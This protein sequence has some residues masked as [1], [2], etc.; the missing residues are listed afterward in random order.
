MEQLGAKK[1]Y[2]RAEADDAT[3]MEPEVESWMEGLQPEIDTCLKQIR[4]LPN[5]ILA[6]MMKETPLEVAQASKEEDEGPAKSTQITFYCKLV[7]LVH[8]NKPS[9][10][11]YDAKN[12][13]EATLECSR[14]IEDNKLFVGQS[15][16]L[17]PR[18]KKADVM[19]VIDAFGWSAD[20]LIGNETTAELLERAIDLKS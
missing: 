12:V 18:N 13:Y 3:G 6:E 10:E 14:K 7:N 15:F 16:S 1:F 19:A 5:A 2:R 17:F 8:I 9:V 11:K 20:E 4:D